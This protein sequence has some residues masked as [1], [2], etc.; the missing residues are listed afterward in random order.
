MVAPFFNYYSSPHLLP[1]GEGGEKE[2]LKLA[3]DYALFP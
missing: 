1:Q 3:I 2:I